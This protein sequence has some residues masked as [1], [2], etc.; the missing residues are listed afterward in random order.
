MEV[1][2]S[3]RVYIQDINK[4]KAAMVCAAKEDIRYHLNGVLVEVHKDQ[5]LM[6]STDGHR[7]SVIREYLCNPV[8]EQLIGK[9]FIVP[10][11]LIITAVKAIDRRFSFYF[12]FTRDKDLVQHDGSLKEYYSVKIGSDLGVGVSDKC[13]DGKY[14]DWRFIIPKSIGPAMGTFAADPA[15]LG[16]YVKMIK[17]FDPKKEKYRIQAYVDLTNDHRFVINIGIDDVVCILMGVTGTD[18]QLPTWIETKELPTPEITEIA[19]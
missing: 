16:D 3:F 13:V 1:G 4:L 8:P 5:V 6:V 14:P 17:L 10:L 11:S 15:Y 18:Y 2:E 7:M 9:S 12:E 19:A